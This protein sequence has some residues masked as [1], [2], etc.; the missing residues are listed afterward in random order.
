MARMAKTQRRPG[1]AKADKNQKETKQKPL[2]SGLS[3]KISKSP[4]IYDMYGGG[5]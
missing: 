4:I 2:K 3:P 5:K 1:K